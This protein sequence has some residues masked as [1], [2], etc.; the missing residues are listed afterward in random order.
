[1]AGTLGNKRLHRQSDALPP[2][3]NGY[4]TEILRA[5]AT[6][7]DAYSKK[8]QRLNPASRYLAIHRSRTSGEV[9]I[10]FSEGGNNGLA[11][12]A[13]CQPAKQLF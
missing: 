2:F 8:V 10:T 12:T 7:I 1:V 3:Q 6:S 9:L 5:D 13:K 4:I 11:L